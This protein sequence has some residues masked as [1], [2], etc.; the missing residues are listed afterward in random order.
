MTVIYKPMQ[1]SQW[2]FSRFCHQGA[3]LLCV[4][5]P[6]LENLA[7]QGGM[8]GERKGE[9]AVLRVVGELGWVLWKRKGKK[10]KKGI[11]RGNVVYSQ[12]GT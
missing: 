3:E 2:V 4:E 10:S 11:V 12:A 9:G 8:Q 5:I 6:A 1:I 7:G